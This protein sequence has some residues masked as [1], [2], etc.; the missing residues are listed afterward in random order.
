MTSE[1]LILFCLLVPG[2]E[3]LISGLAAE[4]RAVKTGSKLKSP[5]D[6]LINQFPHGTELPVLVLIENSLI[7]QKP[8]PV[9]FYS[10]EDSD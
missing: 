9:V 8:K 10:P 3:P 1:G 2:G 7:D 6:V 5:F 4:G